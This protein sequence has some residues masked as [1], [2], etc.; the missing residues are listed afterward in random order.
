[1]SK[2]WSQGY[3][4]WDFWHKWGLK[5]LSGGSRGGSKGSME[6]VLVATEIYR[7][8]KPTARLSRFW[9]PI[10]ILRIMLT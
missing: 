10:K 1:M 3:N 5:I 4:E 8:L 2:D 7:S 6:V 9:Q